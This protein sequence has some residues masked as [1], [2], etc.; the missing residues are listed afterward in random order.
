LEVEYDNLG[1][2]Q[3]GLGSY[4]GKYS[5]ESFTRAQAVIIRNGKFDFQNAVRYP[6]VSGDY[7]SFAYKVVR[8]IIT[9]PLRSNT[10]LRL[11]RIFG[12]FSFLQLTSYVL[13]FFL[14]RW[15]GTRF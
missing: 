13:I 2:S 15:M 11:K 5:F 7:N 6:N 12:R 8:K 4:H 14:G 3:S 1:V 9:H 10:Y